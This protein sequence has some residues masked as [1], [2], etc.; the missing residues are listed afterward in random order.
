MRCISIS[1]SSNSSSSSSS[2]SDGSRCGYIGIC[3]SVVS[4]AP[5]RIR[6]GPTSVG[7][8][9]Q[10]HHKW[11]R[12]PGFFSCIVTNRGDC[13]GKFVYALCSIF[14]LCCKSRELRIV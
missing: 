2:G 8:Q 11:L 9:P 3:W 6:W 5:R 7:V 4:T 12:M 13:W 10:C 1:S 14:L